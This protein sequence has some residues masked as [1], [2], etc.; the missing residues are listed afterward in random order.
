M[1]RQIFTYMFLCFCFTAVAQQDPVLMRINGKDVLR[2]EFE[3]LYNKSNKHEKMA[4]KTPKDFADFF[5]NTKLKVTAAEAAG[6][7][8]TRAFRTKLNAFRNQLT[9]SYLT[10]EET[11]ERIARQYY[12]KM[13]ANRRAGQVHVSQIYK[14]LPQ[15]VS[16]STLRRIESQMDSIYEA[17]K[18]EGANANFDVFVKK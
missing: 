5:I 17:L 3:H 12:D 2:S 6:M 8:T 16:G 9:Q 13:K 7:D 1:I 18:R 14:S 4:Q 10:D 11:T 15:N